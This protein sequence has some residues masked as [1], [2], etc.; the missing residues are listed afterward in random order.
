ME[1]MGQN[2]RFKSDETDQLFVGH[3]V[4]IK[5]IVGFHG[6]TVLELKAALDE[7][8]K[9]YIAIGKKG[10]AR[11]N[12][13]PC[14][15]RLNWR[16]PSEVQAAVATTAGAMGKGINRWASEEPHQAAAQS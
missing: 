11:H 8:V 3:L 13:P 5:D 4:G 9:S 7:P 14:S 2:A 15:D 12:S 6:K 16:I 1:H 10:V